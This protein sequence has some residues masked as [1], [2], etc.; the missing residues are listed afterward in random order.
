MEERK[1]ALQ[2]KDSGGEEERMGGSS[3]SDLNVPMGLSREAALIAVVSMAQFATQVGVGQTLS[4]LHVIAADLDINDPA[5]LSWLMAAY[6]LTVGTFILPSGRFGDVYGYKKM[7]MIGL[8]WFALWSLVA[9]LS[10]YSGCVLFTFARALQGI[11]PAI[12][13]PNA[14]AIL[15]S[16][17]KPS[18]RKNI[19]FSI[20]GSTAPL[21]SAAGATFAALFARASWPWAFYSFAIIL[22]VTAVVTF[23]VVP[24]LPQSSKAPSDK[25][26]ALSRLDPLGCVSGVAALVLFNFAWNQAPVAGWQQPY[27]YVALILGLI[28][29]LVFFYVEIRVAAYPLLPFACLSGEIGAILACIACGWSCFGI[30]LYY[31]WQFFELLR[32]ASP[33]LASAWYSTN[34][35]SG[36]TAAILT[37]VFLGRVGPAKAMIMAMLAFLVGTILIGTA[38]VQQSYWL[39]SFF[40]LL[41]IPFGMDISFPAATVI[42]SDKVPPEHQGIGASL[43]NTVVNYSISLGLGFAGTVESHVNHGGKTEP[44]LLLGFRGAFYMGMGLSGLGVVISTIYWLRTR[45]R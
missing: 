8:A 1:E 32:H 6:S 12:C 44:D 9:G 27:V 42:V 10:V 22:V 24:P 33:L 19:V 29:V 36:A 45:N 5:R 26:S 43:I 20:F 7:Y 34:A 31:T 17:Y 2:S 18:T 40:C 13:L 39:Q 41:V 11:G 25:A 23:L 4:I 16:V 3:N 28:L 21:G 15:G 35:V 30:F 37:G 14:M 38:P